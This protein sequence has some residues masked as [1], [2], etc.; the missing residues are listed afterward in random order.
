MLWFACVESAL[1]GMELSSPEAAGLGL[2][3]ALPYAPSGGVSLFLLHPSF[4]CFQR[5]RGPSFA[6]WFTI[7]SW[8]SAEAGVKLAQSF[9]SQLFISL[10]LIYFSLS[11]NL[12]FKHSIFERDDGIQHLT[13]DETEYDQSTILSPSIPREE[14]LGANVK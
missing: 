11:R 2:K 6:G 13:S 7:F 3:S 8:D 10:P 4:N 1:G 5:P 9:S 14:Q 12:T